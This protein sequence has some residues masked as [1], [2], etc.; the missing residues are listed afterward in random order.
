MGIMVALHEKA[1]NTRKSYIRADGIFSRYMTTPPLPDN[2]MYPTELEVI[3]DA[4]F[5]D[6]LSITEI[7][8]IEDENE[9]GDVSGDDAWIR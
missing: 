3:S 9:D 2:M 5:A 6:E 8:E 7:D 1:S 4:D